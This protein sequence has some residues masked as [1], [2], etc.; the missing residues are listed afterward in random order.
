MC[1][2]EA[3]TKFDATVLS[4]YVLLRNRSLGVR[5]F[6]VAACILTCPTFSSVQ[7]ALHC[8]QCT[9]VSCMSVQF[10]NTNNSQRTVTTHLNVTSDRFIANL[11]MCVHCVPVK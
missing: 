7:R 2:K 3:Y 6:F 4:V 5:T 11:L 1:S 8:T 10:L 9:A